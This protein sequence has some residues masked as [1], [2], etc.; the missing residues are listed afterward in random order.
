MFT[1][2]SIPPNRHFLVLI[3]DDI[4]F[5]YVLKDML[6]Y[7]SHGLLFIYRLYQLVLFYI[8]LIV[9]YINIIQRNAL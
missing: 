1:T 3:D 8:I 9:C 4:I 7:S 5:L 2:G 6:I